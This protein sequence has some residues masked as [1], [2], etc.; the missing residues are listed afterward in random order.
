[1]QEEA[2]KLK[3]DLKDK[4][5]EVIND[6]KDRDDEQSLLVFLLKDERMEILFALR[7]KKIEAFVVRMNISP[8]FN[9]R[10]LQF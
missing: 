4:T 9:F 2:N 6:A 10:R 3:K 7:E 1:M 5:K 8:Q